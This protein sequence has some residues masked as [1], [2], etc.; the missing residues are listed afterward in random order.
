MNSVKNPLEFSN[1]R[2]VDSHPYRFSNGKWTFCDAAEIMLKFTPKEIK[3]AGH[4]IEELNLGGGFGVYIQ[5]EI[6][7]RRQITIVILY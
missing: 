3:Q 5:R 4:E 2:L 1:L 7:L 6:I